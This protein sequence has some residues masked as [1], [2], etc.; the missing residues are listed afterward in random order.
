MTFNFTNKF[1][2]PTRHQLSDKN[3]ESI[4]STNLLGTIISNDLKWNMN[5]KKML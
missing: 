2:F 4:D 1:Q 3:L 5:N